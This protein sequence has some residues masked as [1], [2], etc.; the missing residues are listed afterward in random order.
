MV[1]AFWDWLFPRSRTDTKPIDNMRERTKAWP[2][3]SA[4]TAAL[5]LRLVLE[6]DGERAADLA[7]DLTGPQLDVVHTTLKEMEAAAVSRPFLTEWWRRAM[8]VAAIVWTLYWLLIA[9]VIWVSEADHS[10]FT[11]YC[12]DDPE[13]WIRVAIAA[14]GIF[15]FAAI[16]R[17]L[18]WVVAGRVTGE[19]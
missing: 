2:P 16:G 1:K 19:E 4:R 13:A 8:I 6:G 14:A 18:A 17:G 3:E 15:V 10:C 12:Y 5:V 11:S 7:Q 9:V